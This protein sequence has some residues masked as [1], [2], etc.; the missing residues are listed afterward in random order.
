MT[1]RLKNPLL[2][3]HSL[4]ATVISA[5]AGAVPVMIVDPEHFN[6]STGWRDLLAVMVVSG[7]IALAAYLKEHPVP[8]LD[9]EN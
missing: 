2:W 9:E 7:G 6:I 3:L 1:T 5:A 8:P 4:V